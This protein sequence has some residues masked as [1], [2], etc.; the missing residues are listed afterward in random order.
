MVRRCTDWLGGTSAETR[1]ETMETVDGL[2]PSCWRRVPPRAQPGLTEIKPMLSWP[3]YCL[4]VGACKLG[5]AVGGL[6]PGGS[7]SVTNDHLST[8]EVELRR[9]DVFATDGV[10]GRIDGLVVRPDGQAVTHVLLEEGHM[11]G[12]K[13]VAIPIGTVRKLADRVQL[14]LSKAEVGELPAVDIG[15]A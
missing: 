1:Y 9:G 3:S 8:G 5:V 13:R 11:W 7:H 6:G 2:R 15:E 12:R 14:K 4:G 10:I